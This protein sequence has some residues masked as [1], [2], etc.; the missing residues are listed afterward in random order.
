MSERERVFVYLGQCC[1]GRCPPCEQVCGRSLDCRNHKCAAPCHSGECVC[2]SMRHLVLSLSTCIYLSIGQCYPCILTA[3]VS[4]ACKT[5]VKTVPCAMKIST[6]PPRCREIC[7]S[8]LITSPDLLY[9]LIPLSHTRN[10]KP[11][12]CHHTEGT[13]SII[14]CIYTHTIHLYTN[15]PKL[16]HTH[17]W[18]HTPADPQL[19]LWRLPSLPPALWEGTLLRTPLPRPLPL[20]PYHR[21]FQLMPTLTGPP[22][23]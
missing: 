13:V 22:E 14:L 5:S 4:C 10:R 21:E 15:L 1:D 11:P 7:K 19:P 9:L 2:V 16:Y 17:T 6:K 12:A 18:T 20:P 23:C 3:E 8:A